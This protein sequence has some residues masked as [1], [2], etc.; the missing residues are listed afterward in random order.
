LDAEI[1]RAVTELVDLAPL[2]PPLDAATA[3]PLRRRGRALAV[4]GCVVVAVALVAAALARHDPAGRSVP[5]AAASTIPTT[6][7]PL[8][9]F[10]PPPPR[11]V[12]A[13]LADPAPGPNGFPLDREVSDEAAFPGNIRHRSG[14][15]YLSEAQV[16]QRV[17]DLAH[18]AAAASPGTSR[19]DGVVVR[20]FDS[21]QQAFRDYAPPDW[22]YYDG[23]IAH[24]REVYL[25]T[26][27][28][29][30]PYC[31]RAI[32]RSAACPIYRDHQN[33]VVDATTGQTPIG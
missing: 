6:A 21:Y 29:A 18:C 30:I 2:P 11:P 20:Y 4:A 31:N 7:G 25:A 13:D 9:P 16:R 15:P 12:P 5:P 23:T 26:V 22:S 33:Y 8:L 14:G 27:Y 24:D 19:C 10:D 1:R 17:R 3:A 28:G 32:L